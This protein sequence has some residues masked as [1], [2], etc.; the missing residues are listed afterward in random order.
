MIPDVQSA[1]KGAPLDSIDLTPPSSTSAQLAVLQWDH[2]RSISIGSLIGDLL[3]PTKAQQQLHQN[4]SYASI[5]LDTLHKA[6]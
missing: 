3:Q 1:I 6:T 2:I 5:S 4:L